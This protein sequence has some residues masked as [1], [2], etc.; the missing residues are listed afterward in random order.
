MQAPIDHR[1]PINNRYIYTTASASMAQGTLQKR[2]DI[3][4]FRSGIP[5]SGM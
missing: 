1:K 5:G 4:I 3:N 2:R